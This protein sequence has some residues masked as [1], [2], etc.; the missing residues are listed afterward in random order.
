[1]NT[2]NLQ[3]QG[4]CVAIAS[5]MRALKQKGLLSEAEVEQMLAEAEHAAAQVG[6]RR[7]AANTEAVTFP[8]RFL[9]AVNADAGGGSPDFQRIARIV[10]MDEAH[11]AGGSVS[12]DEELELA[13]AALRSRDA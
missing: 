3:L 5:L 11:D 13:R 9:R 1:M 4:L 7:R 10:G 12:D 8:I 2:A 6:D